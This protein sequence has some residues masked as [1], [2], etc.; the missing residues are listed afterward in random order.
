[1]L[2]IAAHCVVSLPFFPFTLYSP[3]LSIE[4]SDLRAIS[5]RKPR[6]SDEFT[7]NDPRF[8][9]ALKGVGPY[10]SCRGARQR[11]DILE[12]AA[13]AFCTAEV[14]VLLPSTVLACL[15][16]FLFLFSVLLEVRRCPKGTGGG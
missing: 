13:M 11:I 4:M 12:K 7:I 2:K 10:V 15:L 16:S 3:T 6:A 1:M 9:E 14:Y 5:A 8:V